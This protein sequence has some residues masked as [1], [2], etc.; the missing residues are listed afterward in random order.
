MTNDPQSKLDNQHGVS[1]TV[2]AIFF[3]YGNFIGIHH[4]LIATKRTYHH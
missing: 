1:V 4:M 2:K 3:F